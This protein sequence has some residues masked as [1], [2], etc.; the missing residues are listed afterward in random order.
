[1]SCLVKNT[2]QEILYPSPN[3]GTELEFDTLDKRAVI[4]E[5]PLE[6]RIEDW[7]KKRPTPIIPEIETTK[8]RGILVSKKSFDKGYIISYTSKVKK[9]MHSNWVDAAID[10]SKKMFHVIV[11]DNDIKNEGGIVNNCNNDKKLVKAQD[12]YYVF[13]HG[14]MGKLLPIAMIN[15]E[16]KKREKDSAFKKNKNQKFMYHPDTL[17]EARLTPEKY[18]KE[19]AEEYSNY[20]LCA[21]AWLENTENGESAKDYL[22]RRRTSGMGVIEPIQPGERID[23]VMDIAENI[24]AI[25]LNPEDYNQFSL[26]F[27]KI[28]QDH[29][30]RSNL[31]VYLVPKEII[32]DVGYLSEPHGIFVEEWDTDKGIS[33]LEEMQKGTL[34]G[35]HV[36]PEETCICG[37][38]DESDSD[39]ENIG[40]TH[41]YQMRLFTHELNNPRVKSFHIPEMSQEAYKKLK[42]NIKKFADDFFD[43]YNGLE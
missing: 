23:F 24:F 37:L 32:K 2:S 25:Y 39:G 15:K 29:S 1:M 34:Q 22:Y 28:V 40:H 20:V 36:D 18:K 26:K 8:F 38:D 27:K 42:E 12:K 19:S 21:D 13:T 17:P 43:Y 31:W 41:S 11:D 6:M 5:S 14:Q 30:P 7:K 9:T 4:V 10:H 33:I 3:S 35:H 16:F